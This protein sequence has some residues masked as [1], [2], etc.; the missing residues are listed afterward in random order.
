MNTIILPPNRIIQ[1]KN[2]VLASNL[3][4]LKAIER[5]K[6]RHPELSMNDAAIRWIDKNAAAWRAKHP[7]QQIAGR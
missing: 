3:L 7:L 4:E 2:P 5:Y 1:V 6:A